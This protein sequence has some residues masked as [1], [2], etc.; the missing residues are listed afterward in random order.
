MGLNMN[1]TIKKNILITLS[2]LLLAGC[3]LFT[4]YKPNLQQGNI[5]TP[6]MLAQLHIGL[7]T[8]QV[9]TIMES[10]P[11]LENTFDDGTLNYVYTYEPSKGSLS[12]KKLLLIFKNNKLVTISQ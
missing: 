2:S 6:Q 3:G 9:Q 4:P 7:T 10:A 12:T 11:V 8:D 1:V 5:I